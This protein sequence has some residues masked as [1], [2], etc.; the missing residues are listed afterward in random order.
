MMVVIDVGSYQNA[1]RTGF[2]LNLCETAAEYK[3]RGG[4]M[5]VLDERMNASYL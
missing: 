2:R 4:Q 5:A 3:V 1:V